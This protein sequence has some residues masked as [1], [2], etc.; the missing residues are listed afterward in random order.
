MCMRD[1]EE[2][3][4]AL[5]SVLA[6]HGAMVLMLYGATRR[7]GVYLLQDVFRRLG[8]R[9]VPEDVALIRDTMEALPPY[10]YLHFYRQVAPDL[11]HDSGIVDTFLHPQDR[12]YTVPEVLD[13]VRR[14]GLAFQGWHDNGYYYPVGCLPR[15]SELRTRVEALPLEQQWAIVDNLTLLNGCHYFIAC[16]PGR[17]GSTRIDFSGDEWLGYV[18]VR[19]PHLT[20]LEETS[21]EPARRGRARRGHLE[22]A[23]TDAEAVLI[24]GADGRR[25]IAQIIA[26]PDLGQHSLEARTAFAQRVF[27]RWWEL[28][29]L[30]MARPAAQN[31]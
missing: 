13:L 7:V 4:R 20:I 2:G 16:H 12:A 24:G 21:T 17:S 27:K 31:R 19:H 25:T 6:E 23:F 5:A 14:G 3:L 30:F 26:H 29:H 10:H 15:G 28:G 8:L 9:Q 22:W 1:P 18:P 11:A